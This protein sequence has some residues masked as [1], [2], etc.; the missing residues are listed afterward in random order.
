MAW[1]TVTPIKTAAKIAPSVPPMGLVITSRRVNVKRISTAEPA[2]YIAIRIGAEL[3]KKSAIL[4]DP[5]FL[6]IMSGY[7]TDAGKIKV[8]VDRGNGHFRAS[9]QKSGGYI[10]TIN[11]ASA[12]G[13]F[14]LE[15]PPM[16]VR[17]A[18]VVRPDNGQP[19][20]FH[21]KLEKAFFATEVD[22]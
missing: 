2:R 22:E 17:E 8:Q 13:K 5:A 7:G 16:V 15:F 10:V 21:C 9:R 4:S 1:D 18:E 11:A 14:A 3:A 6:H 12:E 19:V 20:F